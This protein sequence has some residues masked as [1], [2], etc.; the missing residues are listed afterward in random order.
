MPKPPFSAP[1]KTDGHGNHSRTSRARTDD[2]DVVVVAHAVAI[3]REVREWF[4]WPSVL[5]GAEKG[6]FGIGFQAPPFEGEPARRCSQKMHRTSVGDR[7]S[8]RLNSSH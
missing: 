4:P 3:M 6:G 5:T 2:N 8:T 1:V 7:K